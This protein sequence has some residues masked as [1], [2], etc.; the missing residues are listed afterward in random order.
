MRHRGN[1]SLLCLQLD[2]AYELADIP[3]IP[4]HI[5]LIGFPFRLFV[6]QGK[7]LPQRP[8]SRLGLGRDRTAHQKD[9]FQHGKDM[10]DACT[11]HSD[12][13]FVMKQWLFGIV[14]KVIPDSPNV[15]PLSGQSPNVHLRLFGRPLNHHGS[16][17]QGPR[18]VNQ[19]FGC[20]RV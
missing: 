18:T 6:D 13:Q 11:I 14:P 20:V 12:L 2:Q 1:Q 4:D 19:I 17:L 7:L 15:I 8:N 5:R 3:A 9:H 10:V 16:T